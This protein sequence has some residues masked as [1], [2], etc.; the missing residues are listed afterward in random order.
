MVYQSI[1]V[2]NCNDVVLSN[3]VAGAMACR[4]TDGVQTE[5]KITDSVTTELQLTALTRDRSNRNNKKK[6]KTDR[7][8]E[9]GEETE[10]RRGKF[11]WQSQRAEEKPIRREE[12]KRQGK[13]TG[14]EKMR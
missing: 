10:R 6:K 11:E 9:A 12:R 3:R 5:L 2:V 4:R 14:C 8:W 1:R 7:Q 13:I